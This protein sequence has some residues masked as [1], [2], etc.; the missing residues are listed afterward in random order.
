MIVYFV[1]G[2]LSLDHLDFVICCCYCLTEYFQ[3]QDI[4]QP[5]ITGKKCSTKAVRTLLGTQC[6]EVSKG[7]IQNDLYCLRFGV[8][9]NSK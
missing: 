8:Q 2:Y 9:T 7:F 5:R 4:T 1:Q 6:I 3:L